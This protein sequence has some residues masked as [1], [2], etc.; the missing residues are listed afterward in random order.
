MLSAHE[1]IRPRHIFPLKQLEEAKKYSEEAKALADA[2]KAL[3]DKM[4]KEFGD[5]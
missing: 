2:A 3:G 1:L 5:A 4:E